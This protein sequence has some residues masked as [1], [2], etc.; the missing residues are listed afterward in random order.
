MISVASVNECIVVAGCAHV[1]GAD[2]PAGSGGGPWLASKVGSAAGHNGL[3]QET[4]QAR[5]PAQ[6]A[7]AM[8]VMD[9]PE[10]ARMEQRSR[11][12]RRSTRAQSR[13]AD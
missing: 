2:G 6:E 7:G 4:K 13:V 3:R 8:G 11:T 5:V 1:A 12:I 9:V 10:W